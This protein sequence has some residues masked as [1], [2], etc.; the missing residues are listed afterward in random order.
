MQAEDR[1]EKTGGRRYSSGSLPHSFLPFLWVM[2]MGEETELKPSGK[3]GACQ[4]EA[5]SLRDGC[6]GPSWEEK[7]TTQA[8]GI[9]RGP[10]GPGVRP[11]LQLGNDQTRE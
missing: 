9:H 4:G 2:D 10:A 1:K 11:G 7:D 3:R 5:R 6:A 8:R